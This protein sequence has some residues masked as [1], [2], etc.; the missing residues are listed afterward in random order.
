LLRRLQASVDEKVAI[1]AGS[2]DILLTGCEV[3]LWLAEQFA[4]DLQK[5]FPKLCDKVVSSNKLLGL[6]GHEL[7]IPCTGY[8]L[9]QVMNDLSDTIILIVSHSGGTF[10]TL[11]SSNLLQ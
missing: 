1:H 9:T 5:A 4:T 3:S 6:F 10:V 7:S 8:P 11:A 2:V